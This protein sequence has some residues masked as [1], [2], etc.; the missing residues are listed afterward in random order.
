MN[1]KVI[2]VKKSSQFVECLECDLIRIDPPPISETLDKHYNNYNLDWRLPKAHKKVWRYRLKLL[3]LL[4]LSKGKKFLDIGCHLGS[5]VEASRRNGCEAYGLEVDSG[6]ISIAEKLFPKCK[7]FNE[8]L[9]ELALRNIQFDVIH[10]TEVI[11]HIPNLNSFM[12]S[13]S[14]IC[15]QDAVMLFSTPDSGHFRVNR[16]NLLEWKELR[17]VS[18][19]CIFNRKNITAFFVKFGF[20]PIFFYPSLQSNLKFIAKCSS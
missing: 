1:S 15:K 8:T 18:H 17:P 12:E 2:G 6:V 11:E 13:L 10:C 3:P 9:E 4:A 14:L 16:K 19:V 20:S 5:M 7:F